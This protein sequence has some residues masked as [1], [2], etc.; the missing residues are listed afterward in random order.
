L[1]N[2]VK[3]KAFIKFLKNFHTALRIFVLNICFENMQQYWYHR[4]QQIAI[5]EVNE[6]S[7]FLFLKDFS[8]FGTLTPLAS[9]NPGKGGGARGGGAH[10]FQKIPR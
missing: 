3:T 7:D 1:H 10:I 2:L 4:C 8:K 5:V 9:E 6:N